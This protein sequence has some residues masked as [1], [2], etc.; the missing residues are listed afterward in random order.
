MGLAAI[1]GNSAGSLVARNLVGGRNP[2]SPVPAGHGCPGRPERQRPL[3]PEG[4]ARQDLGPAGAEQF[5]L[6]LDL[7][8]L[9][10]QPLRRAAPVPLARSGRTSGWR[11]TGRSGRRTPTPCSTRRSCR[12]AGTRP[13][14]GG[15]IYAYAPRLAPTDRDTLSIQKRNGVGEIALL[16]VRKTAGP[17]GPGQLAVFRRRVRERQLPLDQRHRRRAPGHRGSQRRRLERERHLRQGARQGLRRLRA[18]ES[19]PATCRSWRRPTLHGPWKT[20]YY[21]RLSNNG[22]GVPATSFYYSFLPNGFSGD[23]FTML[24][25]GSYANDALNV[26]DG[27]FVAR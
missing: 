26:I 12:R 15:Y 11:P 24:F 13:I 3:L 10:D 14:G 18:H 8:G 20:V 2:R 6:R 9:L 23:Q 21:G 25:T 16:R 1:S 7:A 19:P 27:R 17:D 22:R 5:P 4:T